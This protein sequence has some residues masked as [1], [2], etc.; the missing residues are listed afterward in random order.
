MPNT[1]TKAV[2]VTQYHYEI[3]QWYNTG[4]SDYYIPFGASTVES[5]YTTSTL[6]DDTFWIVPFDGK[7]IKA[8]MLFDSAPGVCDFKIRQGTSGSNGS[9]RASLM[10][11]GTV[12]CSVAGRRYDFTCDQ[13]NIVSEGDVINLFLDITAKA[14]QGLATTVWEID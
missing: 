5:S 4:T 7:L 6:Y 10:S 1:F 9:L 3:H 8:S 13:N 2:K 12:D 11:G 14:D